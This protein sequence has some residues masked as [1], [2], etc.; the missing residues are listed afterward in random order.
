MNIKK[1]KSNEDRFLN[2]RLKDKI[3][4]TFFQFHFLYKLV[5]PYKNKT[6]KKK[7]FLEK[8]L[9]KLW[10]WPRNNEAEEWEVDR[11]NPRQFLHITDDLI[12]TVNK[13]ISYTP[14]KNSK[15]LDLGCNIGRASNL[16]NKEGY[17]NLYGVDISQKSHQLMEYNYPEL[18][19]VFNYEKNIIQNYLLK[20]KD[21]FFETTFTIGAT[22]ENIHPSFPLIKN[23]CRVT[24]KNIILDIYDSSHSYPRFWEWE[25]NKNG[26]YLKELFRSDSLLS[27]KF[28]FLKN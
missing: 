18:Y 19:N 5:L 6:Y 2:T 22:I 4:N 11:D 20:T 1:I 21:S 12:F 15:I 17:N 14:D 13:I 16:L 25:F 8:F 28:I 26:F 24:N 7:Y 27:T 3:F 10:F 9:Y 23:I